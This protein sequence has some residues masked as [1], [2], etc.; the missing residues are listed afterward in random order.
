MVQSCL[1]ST[2]NISLRE[3]FA[4]EKKELALPIDK[5][6]NKYEHVI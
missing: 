6:Q 4:Q 2:S 5:S 1:V 3:G